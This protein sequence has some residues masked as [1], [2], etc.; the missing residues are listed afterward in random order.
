MYRH[1]RNIDDPDKLVNAIKFSILLLKV[2]Q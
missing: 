2:F 1:N